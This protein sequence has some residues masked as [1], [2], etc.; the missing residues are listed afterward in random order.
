M[1]GSLNSGVSLVNTEL[2]VVGSM[3]V[4]I[5]KIRQIDRDLW[6]TDL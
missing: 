4:E 2:S 6:V 5:R 3:R 1:R